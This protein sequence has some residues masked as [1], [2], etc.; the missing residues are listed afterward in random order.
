MRARRENARKHFTG[1]ETHR[2]SA[3]SKYDR[4][5]S[6]F[7]FFLFSKHVRSLRSVPALC[8]RPMALP[9]LRVRQTL[10]S[11]GLTYVC[12]CL[13]ARSWGRPDAVDTGHFCGSRFFNNHIYLFITRL[14]RR[15]CPEGRDLVCSIRCSVSGPHT[16]EWH[17]VVPHGIFTE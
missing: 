2:L 16:N 4:H 1:L 8:P 10:V 9:A 12:K 13:C 3:D 14:S 7:F 11:D 5:S 15:E 6:S 17:I